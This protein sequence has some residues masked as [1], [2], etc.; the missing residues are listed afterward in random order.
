[1]SKRCVYL[2]NDEE[3]IIRYMQSLASG[4]GMGDITVST[5]IAAGL[6]ALYGESDI[7]A[8]YYLRR[9]WAC[10]WSK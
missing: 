8:L 9:T 1:M 3:A 7:D 10:R 2:S 4:D 5:I 6:H